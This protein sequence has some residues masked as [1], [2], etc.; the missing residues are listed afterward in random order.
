MFAMLNDYI[1]LSEYELDIEKIQ[2]GFPPIA[3]RRQ[4]NKKL[5]LKKIKCNRQVKNL[6]IKSDSVVQIKA[7]TWARNLW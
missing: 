2:S 4:K 7:L 3:V 5:L 1:L 6:Q